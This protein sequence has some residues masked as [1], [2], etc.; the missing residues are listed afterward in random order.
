MSRGVLFGAARGFRALLLL[1][2]ILAGIG[3]VFLGL[4]YVTQPWAHPLPGRP[5]L[6]GYWAGTMTFM[7]G[8]ERTVAV[9]LTESGGRG[10]PEVNLG[11][12]ARMCGAEFRGGE[13]VITGRILNFRGTRFAMGFKTGAAP[14]PHLGGIDGNWDGADLLQLRTKLYTI[15]PDG[16]GHASTS[17]DAKGRLDKTGRISFELRRS[18][19]DAFNSA[20]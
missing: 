20:C 12:T 3:A 15:T 2:G 17:T 7:P 14:G 5:A 9:R 10:S 8:D 18:T 4:G 13:Y 11:G 19:K 16:V 6:V 1:I